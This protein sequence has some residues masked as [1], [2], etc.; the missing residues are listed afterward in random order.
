MYNNDHCSIYTTLF[1]EK[2]QPLTLTAEDT[3]IGDL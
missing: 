2:N 1:S 3:H